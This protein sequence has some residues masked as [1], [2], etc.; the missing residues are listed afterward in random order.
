MFQFRPQEALSAAMPTPVL[1]RFGAIGFPL[2]AILLFTLST[3]HGIG[4]Y[5]DSTRYMGLAARPWDAPLYPALLHLVA[6]TGIDIAAGAW[7][8]GLA[9]CA[10]N[11]FLTWTVLREA[12]GRASYAALGTA[13]VV[14]AP[15][16]VALHALAMSE[17]LFLTMILASMWA[18]LNYI[19]SGDRPWLLGVGCGVGFASLVRFTGPP[20]GAAIALFLLIDPRRPLGRRVADVA[21]VALP[22]ALLFLGWAG[23]SEWL[24]GRSTGRPLEW[25]GN[26]TAGDWLTS[27]S[28]LTAWIV[29]D[30]VPFG[31]RAALFLMALAASLTLLWKHGRRALSREGK[32]DPSVL[33]VPLGLFFF[34]YL[35]F[36]VLATSIEAN[37]HLNSRYAYP[38]Y[39]TSV[40][41]MTIVLARLSVQTGGVRKLHGA[42]VGLALFMGVSHMLRTADR[43][44]QA[45]RQGLGF[46]SLQWTRSPT[47]AAL[48]QLP[49]DAILYSNGPDAIGYVL[50]RPARNIPAHILLR[51]GREDPD[52]PYAAQLADARK[53]LAGGKAYIVFLN[54]VDWRFYMAGEAEL[55]RRLDLRLI[56]RRTDGAIY[57]PRESAS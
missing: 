40:M 5:P 20:L 32:P 8:I 31:P 9:L 48:G 51:T 41:A 22:S 38:V 30:E 43:V 46:A 24:I 12:S 10:I 15:Q 52:F 47:L 2:I 55:V 42:L 26:M 13:L 3:H 25:L 4:I 35:G 1:D 28:A 27:F 17:P 37:L 56:A 39:C 14:I 57:G 33:A 6:A 44:H 16:T 11:A 7:G 50:R 21:Y 23:I 19:R 29:P 45:Y 53:A 36:I 18:L 49:R 34:T 54:G